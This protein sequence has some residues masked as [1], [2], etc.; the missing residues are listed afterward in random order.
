MFVLFE[1]T[2]RVS[3]KQR[4]FQ[5]WEKIVKKLKITVKTCGQCEG[6]KVNEER[7][8]KILNEINSLSSK[9]AIKSF[10]PPQL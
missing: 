5:S 2:I 3:R 1:E 10:E 7:K 4:V 9:T 6:T 8:T